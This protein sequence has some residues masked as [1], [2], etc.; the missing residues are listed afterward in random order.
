[1]QGETVNNDILKTI[2]TGLLSI[3][4]LSF[5]KNFTA[6]DFQAISAGIMAWA[7]GLATIYKILHDIKRERAKDAK[8]EPHEPEP[9]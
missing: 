7:V 1:M 2:Y 5:L 4:F 8:K 6:G 3:S 9:D